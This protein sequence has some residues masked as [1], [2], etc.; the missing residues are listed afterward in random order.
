MVYRTRSGLIQLKCMQSNKLPSEYCTLDLVRVVLI[1][2][3]RQHLTTNLPISNK[4]PRHS[5]TV[6]Q[7]SP[8]DQSPFFSLRNY[9][10]KPNVLQYLQ[11][12]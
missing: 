4:F 6:M 10:L 3:V 1:A 12:I 7:I 5:L 9:K 11:C 8:N 2:K